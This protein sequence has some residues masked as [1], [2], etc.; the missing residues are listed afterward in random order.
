M[1]DK[2]DCTFRIKSAL[3]EKQKMSDLGTAK[4][5][6]G[7]ATEYNPNGITINQ[8]ANIN[9]VLGCFEMH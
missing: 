5:F 2:T 1:I 8:E 4:L 7:F 9:K 3:S 6:L